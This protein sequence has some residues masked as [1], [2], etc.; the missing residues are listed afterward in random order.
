M[1]TIT[2]SNQ[3]ELLAALK[4]ATGGDTIL[5]ADGHYGDVILK[6]DYTSNVIIKAETALGAQFTRIGFVGATNITIDGLQVETG[7]AVEGYSKGIS[8]LNSDVDGNFYTRNVDGLTLDN[9]DISGGRW[10][11]LLN[12]VQNF[13]I[14]NSYIHEVTEDLMRITGNSY[15]GLIENNV[16]G[17]T[18]AQKP[19]HPDIIQVF[20]AGGYVPH[21]ITIRGNLLY[22]KPDAGYVPAQGI[23]FG[24]AG[25]GEENQGFHNILIENNLIDTPAT[26]T[27]FIN[28]GSASVQILNNTLMPRNDGGGNIRLVGKVFEEGRPI[29]EGNVLKALIIETKS[30]EMGDN[31]FY[32]KGADVS[33]LF[34]G[35]DGSNWESFVPPEGS[36]I[37]FGS[38]YGA[39]TR[40]LELLKEHAALFGPPAPLEPEVE[41][42]LPDAAPPAPIEVAEPEVAAPTLVYAHDKTVQLN[43]FRNF[44][45]VEHMDKMELDEGSMSL[46]FNTDVTGWKRGLISKDSAGTGDAI[47]AWIYDGTLI[48]QFQD[49]QNTVSF[50][51]PGIKTHQD[52][53]LLITFDNEKVKVWLDDALI[54]EAAMDVDLSENSDSLVIGG[55]NGHSA[56]G[57][58]NK[59]GYFFDGTLSDIA[60]YD[61]ALTP[62]ELAALDDTAHA[63]MIS[64]LADSQMVPALF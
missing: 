2:V 58:T 7:L 61:K 42:A 19:L 46:T 24:S 13:S 3:S 28:S 60:I 44:V 53:D 22:D 9:V 49:G 43:G 6:N 40:L 10:G 34:S 52:Y 36:P 15:N 29:V 21:D 30:V 37:D 1:A 48:V 47:S 18:K 39:Q 63:S 62:A 38:G 56:M 33:T 11:I 26:N 23:F 27:I 17:D 45:S 31:Y 35:T 25:H 5:L 55:F 12:S 16:I 32:G 4:T 59:T 57:T 14:T 54:G 50:K 64:G 20:H 41:A 8:V 51:Q